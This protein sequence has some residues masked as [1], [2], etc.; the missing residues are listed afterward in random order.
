MLQ[1]QLQI[2]GAE[3]VSTT[4]M[5]NLHHQMAYRLQNHSLD[6][7]TGQATGIPIIVANNAQEDIP[8]LIEVP[9]SISREELLLL[10]PK[11]WII[12]YENCHQRHDSIQSSGSTFQT[13]TNERV[14]ATF[15]LPKQDQ[16]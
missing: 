1:V 14:K 7:P 5:A 11:I 10:M 3:Q 9:K 12:N 6:L 2:T 8:T 15:I 4:I 16:P 13:L